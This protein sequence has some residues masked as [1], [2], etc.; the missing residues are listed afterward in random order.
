MP[1]SR[2]S[3]ANLAVAKAVDSYF[4]CK[5]FLASGQKPSA[6]DCTKAQSTSY[7]EVLKAYAFPGRNLIAEGEAKGFSLRKGAAEE[8]IQRKISEARGRLVRLWR[9]LGS[10]IAQTPSTASV[11][12]ADKETARF[13]ELKLS[14]IGTGARYSVEENGL[15]VRMRRNGQGVAFGPGDSGSIFSLSGMAPLLTLQS[16]DNT[17]TS[18][19]ASVVA[20][21]VRRSTGISREGRPSAANSSNTREPDRSN[22]GASAPAQPNDSGCG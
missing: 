10:R 11:V 16:V 14:T 15:R 18:G 19:G 12:S 3:S 20:L 13:H 7:A 22:G 2:L 21:P 17:E 1:T 9:L 6:T 4:S 5:R 8:D